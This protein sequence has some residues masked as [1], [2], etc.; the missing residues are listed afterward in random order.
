MNG[1]EP[2]TDNTHNNKFYPVLK[3]YPKFGTIRKFS[4]SSAHMTQR[5][6]ITRTRTHLIVC[7]WRGKETDITLS[8]ISYLV[9]R[10]VQVGSRN[11]NYTAGRLEI[12]NNA[13]ETLL[14]LPGG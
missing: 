7:D 9:N 12:V 5:C 3:P 2:H 13:G 14:W 10:R 11:R 8:D 1:N 4:T 6:S